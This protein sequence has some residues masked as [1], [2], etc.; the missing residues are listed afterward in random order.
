MA[1]VTNMVKGSSAK[2]LLLLVH[3]YGADEQDLGGLLPYLDPDGVFAAV[4]PRA[5]LSA[6]GAPGYM[7]YD[8]GGAGDLTEQ[9]TTAL[10]ELDVLVDEQCELL[11]FP[12]SEAVFAGFSQGG[13]LALAL[14]LFSAPDAQPRVRPAGVLAMSPA[15]MTGPV[16]D[17]ARS[18]PVLVQHGTDDPMIA[19]QRS[20][21][22]A[23]DLRHFGISTISHD[24]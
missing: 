23:R 11:G 15:A 17:G 22:L 1:L 20:R 16:D 24:H 21:D 6:S 14:G 7:W 9:F 2:R 12:R 5:P 18:V 19:V 3:G 8:M 13:G 10:H 4:M